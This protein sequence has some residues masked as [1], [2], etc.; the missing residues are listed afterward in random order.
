MHQV[1]EDQEALQFSGRS[2]DSVV[3]LIALGIQVLRPE[4]E[5]VMTD[6]LENIVAQ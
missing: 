4:L 2:S 1:A 3:G 5:Y 6:R